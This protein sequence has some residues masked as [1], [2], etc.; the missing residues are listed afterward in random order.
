M[1]ARTTVVKT[2][3]TKTSSSS[4][5]KCELG[6]KC[7]YIAE[8]Q[9]QLEFSHDD[10]EV[11]VSR[12]HNEA[13]SS[14][15]G[16]F[17]GASNRLGG[18]KNKLKSAQ[19]FY[20][21]NTFE[22][23]KLATITTLSATD[24][25]DTIELTTKKRTQTTISSSN[26]SQ[27]NESDTLKGKTSAQKK[28]KVLQEFVSDKSI[29]SKTASNI[30]PIDLDTADNDENKKVTGRKLSK[31]LNLDSNVVK[32][33]KVNDESERNLLMNNTSSSNVVGNDEVNDDDDCLMQC[34][35]C[36]K[37][38]PINRYNHHSANCNS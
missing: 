16:S 8:Y 29:N 28:I 17:V 15:S 7:P 36:N 10:K 38:I 23:S 3:K 5:K 21:R 1:I 37:Y 13:S 11:S 24:T 22:K 35:I 19:G 9:H 20:N 26:D 18:G 4:K 27:R 30:F 34:I 32:D 25:S 12:K 14:S 31:E 6:S 2:T 33:M